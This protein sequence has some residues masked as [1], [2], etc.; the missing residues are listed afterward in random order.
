MLAKRKKKKSN[1]IILPLHDSR[2]WAIPALFL[3]AVLSSSRNKRPTQGSQPYC[4]REDVCVDFFG[5]KHGCLLYFY[6]V[7]C[8]LDA[9][10]KRREWERVKKREQNGFSWC[11]MRDGDMTV[12][13]MRAYSHIQPCL[14]R[15]NQAVTSNLDGLQVARVSVMFPNKNH[16]LQQLLI[17]SAYYIFTRWY[18]CL[19]GVC[20]SRVALWGT[21]GA[22]FS[23]DN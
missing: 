17:C 11:R 19:A 23:E 2:I 16:F 5:F 1:K 21:V 20:V 10:L 4:F 15:G 22:A 13:S 12:F 8:D 7:Q 14:F 6:I 3:K 18:L 9:Q